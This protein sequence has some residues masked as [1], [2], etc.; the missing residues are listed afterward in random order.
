MFLVASG[1][2]MAMVGAAPAV[3]AVI[4]TSAL[5]ADAGGGSFHLCAVTNAGSKPPGSGSKVELVDSGGTVQSSG[6]ISGQSAGSVVWV[7]D[8]STGGFEYC[9]VTIPGSAKN[10]RANLA[11]LVRESTG[12]LQTLATDDAR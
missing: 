3:A 4:Q 9:R 7:P 11:I 5:W 8:Y 10:V 12:G 6:D 1:I 2:A